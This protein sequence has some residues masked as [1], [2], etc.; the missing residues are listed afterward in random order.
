MRTVCRLPQQCCLRLPL[1]SQR[2]CNADAPSHDD[3]TKAFKTLGST[4][5]TAYQDLRKRYLHLAKEHHPDVQAQSGA[6]NKHAQMSSINEAFDVLTRANKAGTL[7][8][9]AG[10]AGAST[11]NRSA[12]GAR[13]HNPHGFAG[14]QGFPESSYQPIWDMP[15]E[16]YE[17]M[18]HE[19]QDDFQQSR[20]QWDSRKAYMMDDDDFNAAHHNHNNRPRGEHRKGPQKEQ[21]QASSTT[22]WKQSDLDALQNMYQDGRSF[23][24]IANALGKTKDEVVEEFNRWC[25]EQNNVRQHNRGGGPGRG[26][27]YRGRSRGRHENMYATMDYDDLADAFFDPE[28]VNEFG[29][30]LEVQFFTDMDAGVH[31]FSGKHS[32]HR[33]GGGRGQGRKHNPPRHHSPHRGGGGGSNNGKPRYQR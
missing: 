27:G 7:P 6:T 12:A 9:A 17:S 11:S 25:H 18:W 20:K 3:V 2:R 19:M 10:S 5:G 31:P 21:Q 23:E 29:E 28:A 14:F 16:F 22:T 1:H 13:S 30:P 4:Q 26:R 24:F 32:M 33:G 8:K 15:P